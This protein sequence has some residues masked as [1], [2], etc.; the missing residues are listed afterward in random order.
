MK[1]NKKNTTLKD[2]AKRSGVSV[3][4]SSR[5]LGNYGYVDQD[6][7]KKVLKAAQ[8]LNYHFNSFA[9]GLRTRRTHT[10]GFLLP[11][12]TNPFYTRIAK[13]IQD[14]AYEKGY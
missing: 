8:D 9:K 12:I 10:I 13:G 4:T 2:V 1:I 11:D 5:A 6:T 7:K 3:A 14:V